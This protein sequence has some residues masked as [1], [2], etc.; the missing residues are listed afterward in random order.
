MP[1][2]NNDYFPLSEEGNSAQNS[3]EE[4]IIKEDDANDGRTY[5][6]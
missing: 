3:K 2:F 1:F 5:F 6:I 4:P